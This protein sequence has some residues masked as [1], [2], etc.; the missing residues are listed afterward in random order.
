MSLLRAVQLLARRCSSA[1]AST[2]SLCQQCHPRLPAW[3]SARAPRQGP[4][5]WRTVNRLV[6]G[7]A[8]T[9][10]EG[11]HPCLLHV[12]ILLLRVWYCLLRKFAR[13]FPR[14]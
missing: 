3:Q 10:V 13:V 14:A 11:V 7:I 9:P 2:S 12:P 6:R 1:A 5:R 8:Q 4:A